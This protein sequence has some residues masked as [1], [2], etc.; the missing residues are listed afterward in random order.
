MMMI[1]GKINNRK[2]S[3]EMRKKAS[4][5]S[6]IKEK[7]YNRQKTYNKQ[8]GRRQEEEVILWDFE[9]AWE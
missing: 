2:L 3:R 4:S 6:I 9:A 7:E 1:Y 8:V 5:S